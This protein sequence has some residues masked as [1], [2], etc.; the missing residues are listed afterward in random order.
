MMRA[1]PLFR[2]TGS[3]I[4]A[5]CFALYFVLPFSMIFT[6]YLIFDIYQPADFTYT[7]TTASFFGTDLTNTQVKNQI[8]SATGEG[9]QILTQFQSPD[10]VDQGLSSS[11]DCNGNTVD[12]LLCS[13]EN[14]MSDTWD[15][16]TGFA[17]TIWNIWKFM[18]GMT[19]DFVWTAFNNP[20][21]PASSSAGLY[22]F[23]IKEV[24]T[25]SPFVI[26][27]T[28]STVVEIIFTM[29]MFRNISA[30]IGGEAELIGITKII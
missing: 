30:L 2:K 23:L 25:V 16:A 22:Y 19:G 29:T 20:L 14:I 11:S 9:S 3:T 1:F 26:L 17:K 12:R 18:M 6:N 4:I 13:G 8:D 28:V 10:L 27:V 21:L 24:Q 7:P 15:A 5:V